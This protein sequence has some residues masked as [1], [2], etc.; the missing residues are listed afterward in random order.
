MLRS[1][2]VSK[3]A[4]DNKLTRDTI[5]E[6]KKQRKNK[7]ARIKAATSIYIIKIIVF[8]GIAAIAIFTSQTVNA[9]LLSALT[10]MIGFIFDMWVLSKDYTS[11]VILGIVVLQWIVLF[12]I[13]GVSV[14]LLVLL[15]TY[16]NVSTMNS[17]MK[18]NLEVMIRV[19]VPV[20]M[21][22]VAIVAPTAEAFYSL[23]ND[24]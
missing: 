19:W 8:I 15:F 22:A 17:W 21:I 14:G 5:N 12:V 16:D 13:I 7:F 10:Y 11:P 20:F 1:L 24:D 6:K 23:P 2:I 3:E 9:L 4:N 18:Q